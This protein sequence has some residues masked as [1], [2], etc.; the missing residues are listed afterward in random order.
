[1]EYIC[2]SRVSSALFGIG[3]GWLQFCGWYLAWLMEFWCKSSCF[4]VCMALV[5]PEYVKKPFP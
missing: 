2:F 1:M 4:Q 3:F 5:C